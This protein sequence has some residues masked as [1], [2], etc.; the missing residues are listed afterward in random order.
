MGIL[1]SKT[2]SAREAA[3]ERHRTIPIHTPAPTHLPQHTCR[4][5]ATD[6]IHLANTQTVT[7]T[8]TDIKEVAKKEMASCAWAKRLLLLAASP[9]GDS[10]HFKYEDGQK[11]SCAARDAL[12][13]HALCAT[14][15]CAQSAL[16]LGSCWIV[17]GITSWRDEYKACR[18]RWS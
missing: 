13:R 16:L 8:A 17:N 18:E 15:A 11:E 12:C 6:T 2:C 5:T 4:N 3:Q 1:S 9:S 10:A 7:T 14:T